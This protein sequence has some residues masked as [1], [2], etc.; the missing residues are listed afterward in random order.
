MLPTFHS[1]KAGLAFDICKDVADHGYDDPKF[2]KRCGEIGKKMGFSR[3][4]D[5]MSFPDQPHFQW[6]AHGAYSG[7][8]ILTGKYLPKMEEYDYMDQDKFNAMIDTYLAKR[9]QLP[10]D[11]WAAEVWAASS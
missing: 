10:V 3:G 11:E 5:W 4:G 2:F 1:V 6:V 9:A 7:S 8:M